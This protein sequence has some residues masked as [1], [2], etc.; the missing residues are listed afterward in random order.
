MR[1]D[2]AKTAGTYTGEEP[3]NF[4]MTLFYPADNLLCLDYNRVIKTLNDLSPEAFIEALG[5]NF[6]VTP[7]EEG[8]SSKV[9]RRHSYSLYLEGKWY[10][11]VV[12]EDK[13]DQ[14][15]PVTRLDAHI[16]TEFVLKGILDI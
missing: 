4:F 11:M 3:F 13:V 1:R 16:I 14:S 15:T 6:T 8:E 9:L 2:V 5:E 12:K 10:R 7:L